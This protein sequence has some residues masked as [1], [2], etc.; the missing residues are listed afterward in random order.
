MNPWVLAE[1]Y[2]A[3]ADPFQFAANAPFDVALDWL[4]SR[5][6]V[7]VLEQWTHSVERAADVALEP[8]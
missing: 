8:G 1:P 4:V 3:S 6:E 2:L 7:P 5:L